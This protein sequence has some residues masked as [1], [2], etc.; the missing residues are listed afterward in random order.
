MNIL[1]RI[2]RLISPVHHDAAICPS[3]DVDRLVDRILAELPLLLSIPGHRQKMTIPVSTALACAGALADELGPPKRMEKSLWRRDPLFPLLFATPQEGFDLFR[4]S[5]DL[6]ATFADQ[7]VQ[8]CFFLLTMQRH[9]FEILGSDLQGEMVLHGV[10]QTVLS[11]E[12]QR[13]TISAASQTCIRAAVVE[14]LVMHLAGVVPERLRRA[15]ELRRTLLESETL[16]EA[17]QHTLELTRKE[18]RTMDVSPTL[19]D[20]LRRARNELSRIDAQLAALPQPPEPETYL[21]QV[22]DVLMHPQDHIK[23]E[24][25]T[26]HV[27]EFGIK[28]DRKEGKEISFLELSSPDSRPLTLVLASL[29]RDTARQI[30]PELKGHPI[31]S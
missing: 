26:M 29:T 28:S 18:V 15:E 4:E 30:W 1:Q 16:L 11:F 31:Q 24:M 7:T 2:Q 8:E 14:E 9:E 13:V 20:Q 22:C 10:L 12:H 25:V 3:A 27:E 17:Q 19:R 6:R 21:V 5:H 23:T